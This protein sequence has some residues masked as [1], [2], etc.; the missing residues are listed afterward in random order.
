V[1]RAMLRPPTHEDVEMIP[2]LGQLAD[3]T[4]NA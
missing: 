3:S 2:L 4:A 1:T